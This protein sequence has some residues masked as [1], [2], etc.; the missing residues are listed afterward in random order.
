[1]IPKKM[2]HIWIGPYLPPSEWMQTWTDAHPNWHYQVYDNEYLANRKWQLQDHINEYMRRGFYSGVADMMRYEIIYE[3]G[4]FIAPADAVCRKPVDDLFTEDKAYTA[5]ENELVRGQLMMP[6]LAAP[7][8]YELLLDAIEEI[9]KIP[10]AHL[11]EAYLSTG[12]LLVAKLVNRKPDL[13]VVLPSHTFVPRH[14]TGLQYEGD[15]DVYAD[16][17]FGSTFGLYATTTGSRWGDFKERFA[18]KKRK[19][20]ARRALRDARKIPLSWN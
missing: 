20:Y 16:Q 10:A 6:F 17:L 11:N 15:G 12:N 18:R 9:K 2:G 4:G 13:A 5:F 19:K 14:L 1:M 7:P 3:N 8:Q